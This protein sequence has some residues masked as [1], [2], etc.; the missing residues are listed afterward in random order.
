MSI[1]EYQSFRERVKNYLVGTLISKYIY[2]GIIDNYEVRLFKGE[3]TDQ[4]ST[5]WK[6]Y[7]K[8]I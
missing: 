7:L 4:L 6:I 8:K 2:L 1:G 5:K 3:K